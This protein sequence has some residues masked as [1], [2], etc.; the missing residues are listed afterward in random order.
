MRASV[1]ALALGVATAAYLG[2]AAPAT[3]HTAS[4]EESPKLELPMLS[5]KNLLEELNGLIGGPQDVSNNSE[6]EE[7]P[8]ETSDD[9]AE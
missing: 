6:S 5:S 7:E 2:L 4:S 8:P 1:A 3:A 9:S